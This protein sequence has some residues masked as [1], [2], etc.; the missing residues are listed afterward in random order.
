MDFEAKQIAKRRI[1][2]LFQQAKKT[3]GTNPELAQTYIGIA[4]RIAMTARVHLPLDFKRQTCKNCN[5]LL[6]PGQT[7]RVRIKPKPKRRT[8]ILVTCLNCGNQKRIFLK[9][10]E[11]AKHEQNNQQNETPRTA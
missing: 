3:Q 9:P 1:E 5:T 8:H 4:R 11:K 10:K 6:V 2:T 7:S